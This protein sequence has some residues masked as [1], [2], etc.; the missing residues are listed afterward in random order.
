MSSF[1][2]K[3]TKE[4][5]VNKANKELKATRRICSNK[6]KNRVLKAFTEIPL[7]VIQCP[8]KLWTI[9]KC[10]EKSMLWP[11]LIKSRNIIQ[12]HDRWS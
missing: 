5:K 4:T 1:S 12:S 8:N 3:P 10:S 6:D 11:N 9:S 2:Q 7:E